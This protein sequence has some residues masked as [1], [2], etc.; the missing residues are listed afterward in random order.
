PCEAASLTQLLTRL[1]IAFGLLR[2]GV[3]H[4]YA[5]LRLERAQCFVAANHDFVALLK[6]FSDLDVGHAGDT[7]LDR[8]EKRLLPIDHEHALNLVLLGIARRR[9]RW[10]REC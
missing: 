9:R 4:L 5:R 7:R 8:A 1:I 2:R 6:S 3:I 10:R